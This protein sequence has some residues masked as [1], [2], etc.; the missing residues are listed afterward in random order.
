MRWTT[1]SGYLVANFGYI[2]SLYIQDNT[3]TYN[4][5]FQYAFEHALVRDSEINFLRVS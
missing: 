1:L 3:Y 2:Y 4:F 5:K